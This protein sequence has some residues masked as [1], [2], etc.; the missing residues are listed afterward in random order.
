ML[1]RQATKF[2]LHDPDG[3][4]WEVYTLDEDIDHHGFTSSTEAINETLPSANEAAIDVPRPNAIWSHRLGQPFP[5]K[6]FVHPGSVDEIRLQGTLNMI[7]KPTERAKLFADCKTAL[8]PGGKIVLHQLT[9]DEPI[10]SN[11]LELVGAAAVVEQVLPIG[12][13]IQ[14]LEAAGFTEFEFQKFQSR[15]CF[16]RQGKELRETLLIAS[17]GE[18]IQEAPLTHRVFFKGPSPHVSIA[19][20]HLMR[21]QFQEAP[22]HVAKLASQTLGERVIVTQRQAR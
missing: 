8:L 6:L 17:E 19:G 18:P 21:G 12:E 9:S 7:C 3:T 2:W 20:F 4:L 1:L 14:E 10:E 15:P 16:V 11:Q 5:T 13:L 22:P